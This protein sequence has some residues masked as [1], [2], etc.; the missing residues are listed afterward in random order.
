MMLDMT[1]NGTGGI[2]NQGSWE[3]ICQ[4]TEETYSG[5]RREYL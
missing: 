2:L 1:C 3:K 5:T 4:I